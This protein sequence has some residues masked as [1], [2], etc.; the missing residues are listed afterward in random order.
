MLQNIGAAEVRFTR[1]EVEEL[2]ASVTAITVQ[3][4]RLPEQVQVF[5]DVE[6]PP[7]QP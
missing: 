6:A 1:S 7:A 5:S 2:N 4:A 3:G